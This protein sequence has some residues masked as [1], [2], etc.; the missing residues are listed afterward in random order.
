MTTKSFQP[1]YRYELKFQLSKLSLEK[2]HHWLIKSNF[3]FGFK[4]AY[5]NRTINN[6]YYESR[7]FRAFHDN[8]DGISDRTKLRVRWYGDLHS[9]KN[10]ILELK[11]KRN[12]QGFKKSCKVKSFDIKNIPKLS[13]LIS[14]TDK[15]FK[16]FMYRYNV[17]YLINTYERQYFENKRHIR[18]T[19]DTNMRYKK[20]NFFNNFIKCDNYSI[21]EIKYKAEDKH[22]AEKMLGS[23]PFHLEKNSKFVNG[24]RKLWHP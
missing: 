18:L 2:F 19:I 16:F 8:E 12:S 22:L 1:D 9:V 13:S 3:G 15:D 11:N 10:P 14:K 7:D 6:V 24:I 17:P 21:L 23:V 5:P 4:T 20:P